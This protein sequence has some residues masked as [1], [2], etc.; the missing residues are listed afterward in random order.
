MSSLYILG[1]GFTFNNSRLLP[2]SK[3]CGDTPSFISAGWLGLAV[4]AQFFSGN[5]YCP[6]IF[7]DIFPSI[8]AS[9][10]LW[11]DVHVYFILTS[12]VHFLFQW[13]C[14]RINRINFEPNTSIP[15]KLSSRHSLKI[16]R[17]TVWLQSQK[18]IL[19]V[20]LNFS[21]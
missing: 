14:W 3:W 12:P 15:W 2:R 8:D 11:L 20:C 16:G 1:P 21:S 5:F 4:L 17:G 10:C 9:V 13:W 19:H 6:S 7:A 18:R